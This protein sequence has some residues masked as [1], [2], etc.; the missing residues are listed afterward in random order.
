M[1][2]PNSVGI[3]AM[4]KGGVGDISVEGLQKRNDRWENDAYSTSKVRIRLNITG[5][6]GD[7]HLRAE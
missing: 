6:V 7:I 1:L 2:L 5:G 3:S 4:S